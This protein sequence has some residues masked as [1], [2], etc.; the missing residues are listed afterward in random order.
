MDR[1]V[2]RVTGQMVR[3][4]GRVQVGEVAGQALEG[5]LGDD[6]VGRS[7]EHGP[8]VRACSGL[9]RDAARALVLVLVVGDD[10]DGQVLFP[11]DGLAADE[12]GMDPALI[13]EPDVLLQAHLG[14]EPLVAPRAGALEQLRRQEA[15]HLRHVPVGVVL[16]VELG[17]A[18]RAAVRLH[19]RRSGGVSPAA[20]F[21]TAV[22]FD[23]SG[24]FGGGGGGGRCSVDG[25]DVLVQVAPVL[26][27]LP[28]VMAGQI[29]A[30]LAPEALRGNDDDLRGLWQ[31]SP[32]Q[33]GVELVVPEA[34]GGEPLAAPVAVEPKPL[35]DGGLV[36]AQ[37]GRGLEA[38]GALPALV[39]LG[40][41]VAVPFVPRQPQAGLEHLAA[42]GARRRGCGGGDRRPRRGLGPL[43]VV[44]PVRGC[45]RGS[46]GQ[47]VPVGEPGGR[48]FGHQPRLEPP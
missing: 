36:L 27:R 13:V 8:R 16:P 22:S 34:A 3:Q 26:E 37:V 31:R 30:L 25:P 24:S 45:G 11:E 40:A 23:G 39:R 14:P 15:V 29:R 19:G 21:G 17:R 5:D 44:V 10:V 46:R 9:D 35:V 33:V 20:D 2:V 38:L 43:G 4:L 12:A 41:A 42:L 47:A 18:V 28:A 48:T 32:V 1:R 7:R 6:I